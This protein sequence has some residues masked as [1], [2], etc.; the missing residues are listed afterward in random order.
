MNATV[1]TGVL[2]LTPMRPWRTP[3]SAMHHCRNCSLHTMCPLIRYLLNMKCVCSASEDIVLPYFLCGH[4]FQ[5]L[6]C[7]KVQY[8]TT[9]EHCVHLCCE[10]RTKH[11]WFLMESIIL[12]V[13]NSVTLCITNK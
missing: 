5:Y 11:C 2:W 8:I 13:Y 9:R 7:I 3:V 10:G 1:D 4:S 12:A 6:P